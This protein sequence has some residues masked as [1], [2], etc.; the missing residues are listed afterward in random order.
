MKKKILFLLTFFY[1]TNFYN[2]PAQP[3]EPSGRRLRD[4]VDDEY[5]DNSII[6]GGTTGAWAFGTSTGLIMD[7]EFNYV[8]PEN[9]F[10]QWC[11][12]SSPT[13]WNWSQPDAWIRHIDANDQIL[14]MHCPIGPQCSSWSQTDSI[15]IFIF[16]N[17]SQST[18]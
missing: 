6:I 15:R 5:P 2:L 9:D 7:Q 3:P 10:K 4:I 11:I 14:R 12:H 1:L 13:S 8:T 17:F 16:N 18:T